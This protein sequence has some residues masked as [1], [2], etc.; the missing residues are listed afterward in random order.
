MNVS[1][2]PQQIYCGWQY[3]FISFQF[4][5]PQWGEFYTH[6][7]SSVSWCRTVHIF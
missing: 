6:K 1:C 4:D 7:K 3:T 5:I 2:P